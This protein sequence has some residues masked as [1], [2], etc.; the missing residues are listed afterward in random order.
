MFPENM[1]AN[2]TPSPNP[3]FFAYFISLCIVVKEK[4]TTG[5]KPTDIIYSPLVVMMWIFL[6]LS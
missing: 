4:N 1:I 6:N 3:F 2:P 5:S